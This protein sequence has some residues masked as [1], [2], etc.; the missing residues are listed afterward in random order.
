MSP[1]KSS[2]KFVAPALLALTAPA[3]AVPFGAEGYIQAFGTPDP[4]LGAPAG[5]VT[6]TC[7]GVVTVV[8][9]S[10]VI[11][12]PTRQI[13]IAE[14]IDPTLIASKAA[15]GDLIREENDGGNDRLMD[16]QRRLLF[17]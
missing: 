1:F 8:T 9:P 3:L 2:L 17:G 13:S 10:T 16:W 11:V 15:L 12:T 5:S 7:G 6:V 14:M 4:A